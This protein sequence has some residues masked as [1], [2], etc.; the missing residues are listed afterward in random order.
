MRSTLCLSRVLVGWFAISLF[1]VSFF[2]LGPPPANGAITTAKS[3]DDVSTHKQVGVIKIKDT[4]NPLQINA[5]CLDGEGHIVAACGDSPGEVRIVD[6]Q[7]QII[8]SWKLEVKPEAINVADDGS[9]LVGGEGQLFRFDSSG[10]LIKSAS[11]PHA[12]KLRDSDSE[13]RQAAIDYLNRR[14]NPLQSRIASYR[15]VIEQLEQRAAKGELNTSEERTLKLLPKTLERYEQMAAEQGGDADDDQPSEAAIQ[16]Q[17]ETLFKSKLRIS[18]ISSTGSDVFVATR[19]IEGYGYDIWKT[20]SEFTDGQI[21]VT[22]LRGCC[23]QMDV[24][25][26]KNGVF[27]AENSRDRVVRFDTAGTEITNWG[28][29]DR[30][31][32]DGFTSCC[33]PMNVTFDDQG[34]VYTAEASSGRIKQFS[35]DGKLLSFV[36]D[37]DLVPGCKN[38]SIAVA[39]GG[40]KVYM[41]DLTRNHIKLMQSKSGKTNDGIEDKQARK[42]YSGPSRHIFSFTSNRPAGE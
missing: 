21:I 6:D 1:A 37:V 28:K 30:T 36:G 38:V 22:G 2:A 26:C 14:R 19:G 23:G 16:A 34:N 32:I 3:I 31:G 20:D 8:R 24:Q 42:P 39:P 7:G 11:S 29:S 13:L 41:L 27:V 10:S 17:V 18:S 33:N 25:C 4:D 35:P 40:D 15:S 12:D 5:F 9:I